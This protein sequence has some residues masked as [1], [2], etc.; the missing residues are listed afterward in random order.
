MGCRVSY[1]KKSEENSDI[2]D[3]ETL[4]PIKLE[5]LEQ[6]KFQVYHPNIDHDNEQ[7][8][9]GSVALP[10][11]MGK[12][13]HRIIGYLIGYFNEDNA[14]VVFT[15]K[16]EEDDLV[17][18]S[19]KVCTLVP[20]Q[21]LPDEYHKD[22]AK[23]ISRMENFDYRINL[24]ID[25]IVRN[26]LKCGIVNDGFL[27][28]HICSDELISAF[29]EGILFHRFQEGNHKYRF[30]CHRNTNCWLRDV[31]LQ[32]NTFQLFDLIIT[33][34]CSEAYLQKSKHRDMRAAAKQAQDVARLRKFQISR[35]LLSSKKVV[36]Q[37]KAS[38]PI[39]KSEMGFLKVMQ[40]LLD[41][42][43]DIVHTL[44]NEGFTSCPNG[45]LNCACDVKIN[46]LEGVSKYTSQKIKESTKCGSKK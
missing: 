3:Q 16:I 9:E 44:P 10:D 46:G 4:V 38:Y 15:H 27:K 12:D 29:R 45:K 6:F 11:D 36:A 7:M 21:C 2:T 40:Y 1:A 8:L 22:P 32:E 19:K 30:M 17:E 25:Y 23:D 18:L 5:Q 43:H 31:P 34:N 35:E 39:T 14:L 28:G 41:G 26:D 42:S 33:N 24:E 13:T 37:Y 20:N